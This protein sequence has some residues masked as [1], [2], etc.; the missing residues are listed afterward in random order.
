MYI[1]SSIND[2]Y[3]RTLNFGCFP[4]NVLE[5]QQSQDYFQQ[6]IFIDYQLQLLIDNEFFQNE[7]L[8]ISLLSENNVSANEKLQQLINYSN[9]ISLNYENTPKSYDEKL[10]YATLM[11]HLYYLQDNFFE[12]SKYLNLVKVSYQARSNNQIETASSAS[13]VSLNQIEFIEYLTTRYYVLFGLSAGNNGV[14]VWLEYLQNF[15][16][17]YNKSQVIANHW[18][19]LL[20]GKLTF[21]LSQ[22]GTIPFSFINHV[23]NLSL[24]KNKLVLIAFSNYLLRPENS[25]IINPS[26]KQDYTVFLTT[27]IEESILVKSQFPNANTANTDESQDVNNFIN[28]LYESLSY[29]PFNLSILKPS[30]SKRYLLNATLK[31]F[32]SKVIL[33]NLIY[34]LI[35]L[36]EYDEALAVFT[37]YIDYLEKDEELKD[38]YIDDILSIIDTFSTCIIHF[39]PLKSFK[40]GNK[41][42]HNDDS[43]VCQHLKK[44]VTLLQKYL[45]ELQKLIDLTYDEE[46]DESDKVTTAAGDKNP[47]SFLYRKYNLNILQSDNTQFIELISKAWYATGYYYYYLSSYESSNQIILQNNISLVL[48]SYKNCLIVNSTGNV[49]Y[50]FSYAL[51]LANSGSLKPALKLCKFILKKFPE[52]FKTW[53]LLVL[54]LSSFD[55][56][57]SDVTKPIANHTSMNIL[58]DELTNG[59]ANAHGGDGLTA[60]G[61]NDTKSKLRE[62]EKFINKALNIAGLYTLKHRQRNI[63]LTVETKYEILQLKLTQLAVLESIHGSQYM[64][65]YLSEVFVL[66]HELF[67]VNLSSSSSNK[68]AANQSSRQFGASDKWS[69]R[70]S[71]IDPSPNAKKN[72]PHHNIN[73]KDELQF[74]DAPKLLIAN[75]ADSIS[76]LNKKQSRTGSIIG[77]VGGSRVEKLKRLSTTISSKEGPISR[78][79]SLLYNSVQQKIRKS[80]SKNSVNKSFAADTSESPQQHLEDEN[81]HFNQQ[82]LQTYPEEQQISKPL[83]PEYIKDPPRHQHDNLIERK[84]LQQVWLWTARVFLKVGLIDECEQCIV[85]AETIYEPNFKTYT[86]LGF[87]TS[88]SRK[89]LS[90]QEFERSLEILTKKDNSLASHNK[91]N[92]KYDYGLTLLGLLKLFLIDDDPKN[93]LF[94]STKDLNS[95]IIRLKNL[96]EDYS[97]TWPY[98]Y[99]N[100]EIW[101]YLTKIYEF[102]DDKILLTKSLWRCIELEDKR[103]V[104][105]FIFDEL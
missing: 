94:I 4:K 16:S 14:N 31:T 42:K 6:L 10:Y 47:L 74:F 103:P 68:N 29:V 25:N 37:T 98:G 12:M 83:K 23:K 77:G 71:F 48:K 5:F 90:L 93:S 2:K 56:D 17:P 22:R 44:F 62:P 73:G 40:S 91:F 54:L 27:E 35:D 9:S 97:L 32:Q 53:N 57:N 36:N 75:D 43:S 30:L 86:A 24:S 66:Y 95:G 41:F 46:E 82:K 100:P 58:P 8:P 92:S 104:R 61:G 45:L 13:S 7:L 51:A 60:N 19:D 28:N 63:K 21:E 15:K 39:N 3:I 38:G 70:P 76:D 102:I 89:F 1:E 20:F 49:L 105:E 11:S 26:F 99:N 80:D 67:E 72:N 101:F 34:T 55:N 65:D 59:N 87:L 81:L 18:L 96:L 64:I 69:H 88:K 50:L 85:E 79:G 52:S 78:R 84:I 33:S